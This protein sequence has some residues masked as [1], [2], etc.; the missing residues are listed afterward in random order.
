ML[1]ANEIYSNLVTNATA[2]SSTN[3]NFPV[4]MFEVD[5][6]LLKEQLR[7]NQFK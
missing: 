6:Y 3:T 4:M 5:L 2:T 7:K 1:F